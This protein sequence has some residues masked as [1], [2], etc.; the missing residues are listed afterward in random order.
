MLMFSG[1]RIHP[2]C[3]TAGVCFWIGAAG[4]APSPPPSQVEKR[5]I[6]ARA[7]DLSSRAPEHTRGDCW[8][9]NRDNVNSFCWVVLITARICKHQHKIFMQV[10]CLCMSFGS[11]VCVFVRRRGRQTERESEHAGTKRDEKAQPLSV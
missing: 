3:Q 4:V 1:W 11:S 6:G 2:G 10:Q 9:S 8:D 7:P 5:S